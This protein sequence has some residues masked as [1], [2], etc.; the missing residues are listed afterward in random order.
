[1]R[2]V[3]V[4][5]SLPKA[6]T[7]STT[8]F[9]LF[10]LILDSL[11]HGTLKMYIPIPTEMLEAEFLEMQYCVSKGNENDKFFTG[12]IVVRLELAV[13]GIC[14]YYLMLTSSMA[15]VCA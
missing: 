2:G 5:L 11:T 6:S 3:N 4:G 10:V 1:M 12:Y 15:S 9:L 8:V 13:G 14:G 7:A